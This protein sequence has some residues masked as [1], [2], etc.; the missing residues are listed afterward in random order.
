MNEVVEFFRSLV[1]VRTEAIFG[2]ITG[3]ALMYQVRF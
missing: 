2:T 1:P 3:A